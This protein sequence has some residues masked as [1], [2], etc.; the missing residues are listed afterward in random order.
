M[1]ETLFRILKR[2]DDA[3]IYYVLGRNRSDTVDVLATF[4]GARLEISVFDDGHVEVSMFT[5][6][7][8]VLDEET[9]N[10]FI[11]RELSDDVSYR[12][13]FKKE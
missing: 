4:V 12:D 7:E 6:S 10:A 2:L 5:G 3:K 8:D 1:S 13:K 9:L 11:E